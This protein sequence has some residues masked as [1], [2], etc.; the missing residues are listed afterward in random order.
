MA[1]METYL[2][3][4]PHGDPPPPWLDLLDKVSQIEIYLH[5]IDEQIRATTAQLEALKVQKA[6]LQRAQ[7]AAK[8]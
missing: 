5:G 7:A 4:W 8:K 6:A 3:Y 2:R 1:N